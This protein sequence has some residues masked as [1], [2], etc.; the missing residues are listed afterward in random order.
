VKEDWLFRWFL[1][2]FPYLFAFVFMTI[3]LGWGVMAFVGISM[4][5]AGPEAIATMAGEIAGKFM[6]GVNNGKAR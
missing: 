5:N 3:L 1:N 4:Y 2:I 6:E